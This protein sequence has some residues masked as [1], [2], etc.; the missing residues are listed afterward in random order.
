MTLLRSN[1]ELYFLTDSLPVPCFLYIRI[2]VIVLKLAC[3]EWRPL[4]GNIIKKR[5]TPFT[6]EKAPRISLGCKPVSLVLTI[7]IW[8]I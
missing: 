2:L 8:L 6:F 5:L 7:R 3:T 4:R 1:C